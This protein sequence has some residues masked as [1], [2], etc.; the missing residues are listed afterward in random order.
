MMNKALLKSK[1]LPAIDLLEEAVRLLRRA[2]ASALVAYYL[3]A[4]P[5]MLAALYFIAD[6]SRS[7]FAADRLF[8]SAAGMA[9]AYLWMKC[10]Q[11]VFTSRLSADLLLKEPPQWTPG[12]VAR[13]ALAQMAAQPTGLILRPAAVILVLPTVFTEIFYQNITVLGDGEQGSLWD[14]LRRS[15]AQCRLWP[16]QAHL[17]TT[18]LV[19]FRFFLWV[20]IYAVIKTAPEALKSYFGVESVFSQHPWDLLNPTLLAASFAG[21]YLCLDPIRKAF[22]VLRCFHGSALR[23]GGDIEVQLKRVRLS[24]PAYGVAAALILLF[25]GWLLPMPV[26]AAM[27]EEPKVNAQELNRS[28]DDVLERREYA[29]RAPRERKALS[30]EQES[31]LSQ[32]TKNLDHWLK[33]LLWKF[34]HWLGPLIEKFFRW[35]FGDGTSSESGS[36]DWMSMLGSV[37]F[38]F[39]MLLAAAAILLAILVVRARRRIPTSEARAEPLTPQPDLSQ[40]NVTADQLPEDGWLNL[41]SELIQR[42][43][44]RLALRASYLASLA[45]LG[46]REL[47]RLAKYK[48]NRDYDRELQRRARSQNELLAAFEGNLQAFERAWYG[49]HPVTPETLTDFTKKLQTIR[50]C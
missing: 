38:L 4:V 21:V 34:S 43:E 20:N 22:T 9:G 42:G 41:A 40:E 11:T 50:A 12:R 14:L 30:K 23:T 2:P 39:I 36:H 19:V 47:I 27:K 25:S 49:E 44:L 32:M 45:H 13:M 7:A 15:Y 24:R 31:W 46:Q 28:L 35:L 10:W 37:R 17:A 18:V 33:R 26:A 5:C 3:G 1:G 48:S 8:E 29:W 16:G 6:M